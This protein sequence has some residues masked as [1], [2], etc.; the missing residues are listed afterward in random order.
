VNQHH[1]RE[2]EDVVARDRE[3][4]NLPLPKVRSLGVARLVALED[5]DPAEEPRERPEL[6]PAA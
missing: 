4:W 2:R 5:A 1:E 6:D 3:A